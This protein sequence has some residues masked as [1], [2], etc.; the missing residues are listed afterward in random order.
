MPTISFN[1]KEF[2]KNLGKKFDLNYLKDRISMLG[3][4]LEGISDNEIQVE[5]FPNRPDMLSMQGFTRA[6]SSF[7]G[8]KK[9][10]ID[11]KINDSKEKVIIDDSVKNI[12]PYTAC[13]IVKS[14]KLNDE[15]IKE[16]I[17][18]QEKL[19]VTYGRNRKKVAIGIYPIEKIKFPITYKAIDKEKIKFRPLE[20]DKEMT[21]KEILEKHTAG[22][23]YK[24]L[25]DG[26]NKYPV[27]I[28]ANNKIMSMPPIINSFETGRVTTKT[29]EI[30]IECSG[31]DF[32][33]LSK[34]L[35]MIAC[36]FYD[37]G[38]KIYSIDLMYKNKITKSPNLKPKK[39]KL[40]IN[41]INRILGLNLSEL[42]IKECLE[43]M[44]YGYKNKE[45]L[46]P[47]FRADILH[48][49]DL[50][51][52]IAIAYGYENFKAIIPKVASVA[53]ENEFE[54]FKKQIIEIFIGLRYL[55]LN[56][57]HLSSNE[58]QNKL[59]NTKKELI[60]L[61]NSISNDFNVLQ[62]WLTPNLVDTFKSNKH[63]D[64]PQKVFLIAKVFSKDENKETGVFE[65]FNLALASSN[66]NANYTEIKQVLD[67]LF[68]SLNLEYE[69]KE[70]EFDFLI[71]GR[72][73]SIV[74]NKKEIGFLGE[75]SPEV[76][77]NWNLIMPCCLF[78]LNLEELFKQIKK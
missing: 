49:V 25:L 58:K 40:D 59:M 22:I 2:E 63:Y 18:M 36:A 50:I 62:S 29:K 3:T 47:C 16:I 8:I 20:S 76:I 13:V 6:F 74:V 23:E 39:M 53:K 4:D 72:S 52:D 14:L 7:V 15:K 19:H 33:V 28:D 68:N 26:F 41:Y 38:A 24:K 54:I 71:K 66:E 45:V 64:Y 35:N 69:I 37:I 32:E 57:F 43:K 27:F 48:M 5:I 61:S 78:E 44:G 51:E 12:R 46:I 31:N 9:G 65:N 56:C 67:Y 10:L 30:F 60:E 21:A 77:T 42:K 1:K 55:Q 70:T 17:Q 11:Y 75:L 34:C 73:A